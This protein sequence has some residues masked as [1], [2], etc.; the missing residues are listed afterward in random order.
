MKSE[1]TRVT[2]HRTALAVAAVAAV[3]LLAVVMIMFL[4][5]RQLQRTDPLDSPELTGLRKQ[6]ID[7]ERG[8]EQ[9]KEH[10]RELDLLSRRAWFTG[11]DLLH[12]GGF[13]IIGGAIVLL[14]ALQTA[15]STRPYRT[16][17][18]GGSSP[19]R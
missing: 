19:G 7:N 3:F 5:Y 8:S 17:L 9:L 18:P 16:G 14:A 2:I 15:A 12:S 11:H 13:L 10:I 4:Q 6:Y 1:A